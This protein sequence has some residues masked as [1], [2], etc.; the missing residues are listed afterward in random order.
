M[1]PE[2]DITLLVL[3]GLLVLGIGVLAFLRHRGGTGAWA[4]YPV[5]VDLVFAGLYIAWIAVE[6]PVAKKDLAT[7]GKRT[8]DAGTCPI[9][10]LGQAGTALTAL[11]FPSVWRAPHVA[12]VAAIL[13]FLCGVLYRL[14]AIRTLGRFYSHRVRRED[15]HR[16]VDSGPY[17]FIRHPAYAGMAVAHAGV[18]LYFFNGAAL[19]FLLTVLIPAIV[20]RI[21]VEEKML[22]QIEGYSDFARTRK[23]LVPAIW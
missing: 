16:I 2:R 17:R 23:R 18:V 21:R 8:C 3:S 9:Y 4:G 11:W 13:V 14:W 15:G 12:H 22:F 1:K 20:L 19:A 7:E 6:A 10:A 5:D